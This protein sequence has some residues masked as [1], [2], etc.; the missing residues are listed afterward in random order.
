[1]IDGRAEVALGGEGDYKVHGM[2]AIYAIL[3]EARDR[4]SPVGSSRRSAA[5][6]TTSGTR[7][8]AYP[9]PGPG[10][11]GDPRRALLRP[12]L[13]DRDREPA[14]AR[15]ISGT[16]YGASVAVPTRPRASSPAVRAQVR[17]R[18]KAS[19]GLAYR[20][21]NCTTAY[22]CVTP[23]RQLYYDDAT[24]LRAKY[25]LVNRYGLRGVGI[26]ALGYDGTRPELYAAIKAKFITDKVPPT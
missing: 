5:R 21:Q 22:G 4:A 2:A 13:V 20:R 1:M 23:W 24:A 8:R 18:S 26:W 15:N 9:R 12:G 10:V 11:Q 7:S 17:P 16:K 19:R 6:R 14:R 25:D 3:R